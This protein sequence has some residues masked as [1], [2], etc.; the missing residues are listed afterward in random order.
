LGLFVFGGLRLL[1]SAKELGDV[2]M[3]VFDGLGGIVGNEF[4]N[5]MGAFHPQLE[6]CWAFL[7][8]G[9]DGLRQEITVGG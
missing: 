9:F 3:C 7:L 6:C 5:R 1:P 8:F 4:D 2:F